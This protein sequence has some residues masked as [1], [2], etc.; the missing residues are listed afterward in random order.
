MDGEGRLVEKVR[1]ERGREREGDREGDRD[2]DRDRERERGGGGGG[3]EGGREGEGEREG[4][5]E[6]ERE[7]DSPSIL[8]S[9]EA[10][11]LNVRRC[12]RRGRA[13]GDARRA[14][15]IAS[16]LPCGVVSCS[17]GRRAARYAARVSAARRGQMGSGAK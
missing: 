17:R 9:V 11:G 8:S 4:E 10:G 16:A 7:R 1:G 5:S 6:R 12:L 15:L 13:Q 3:R 14:V 2:R